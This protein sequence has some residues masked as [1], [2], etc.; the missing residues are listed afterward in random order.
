MNYT[1]QLKHWRRLS[2][3]ITVIIIAAAAAAA[4]ASSVIVSMTCVLSLPVLY[5]DWGSVFILT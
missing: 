3:F 1:S 5:H 4:I 2:S